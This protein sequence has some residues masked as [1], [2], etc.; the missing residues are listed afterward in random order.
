MSVRDRLAV[1]RV[2]ERLLPVIDLRQ[3]KRGD[4]DLDRAR[5]R[6]GRVALDADALA[7]VE[8]ERG[9]ADVGRAAGN[10]RAELLFDRHEVRTRPPPSRAARRTPITTGKS[11]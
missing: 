1:D 7:R 11:Q 6:K 10:Q 2:V 9:D 8:V 3:V 4:R 5:H